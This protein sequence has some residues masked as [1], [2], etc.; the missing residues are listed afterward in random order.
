VPGATSQRFPIGDVL[1]GVRRYANDIPNPG[2]ATFVMNFNPADPVHAGLLAKQ[3]S[4]E[5]IKFEYRVQGKK[6][7][8]VNTKQG[9]EIGSIT[10][11]SV[12]SGSKTGK[13]VYSSVGVDDPRVGDIIIQGSSKLRVIDG[14]HGTDKTVSVES[15]DGGNLTAINNK[16]GTIEKPAV[17]IQFSGQLSGLPMQGGQVITA[18]GQVTITGKVTF[19]TG[20]PDIS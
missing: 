1:D 16:S 8:N 14:L 3:K 10:I 15:V 12:E 20:T 2:N 18:A 4:G 6:V 11:T 13:L 5:T 9:D 17:I 19:I 7:N